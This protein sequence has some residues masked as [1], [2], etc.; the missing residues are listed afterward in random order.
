MENFTEYFIK[1]EYYHV[2]QPIC[3]LP[4]SESI[5]FE[6]LLRNRA[7]TKP[8]LLFQA[9]MKKRELPALDMHSLYFAVSAFFHSPFGTGNKLLFVNLF[10]ST[11]VAESFPAWIEQIVRDFSSMTNRIVVEINESV[12]E[13]EIWG[14]PLFMERIAYLREK[15]FLIALDD[16]GEG[17]ITFRKMLDMSPDFIKIDRYFSQQLAES[18]RK[19]KVVRLFVEYCRDEARLILEGIEQSADVACALELGVVYGQ[20]YVLGKPKRLDDSV[21]VHG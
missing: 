4:G 14:E 20:G 1:K 10:P 21:M 16:V 5:G 2:F 13:E 12:K 6:A 15:G 3:S 7:G 9:A 17:T 19:Q 18:K 8:D 11:I